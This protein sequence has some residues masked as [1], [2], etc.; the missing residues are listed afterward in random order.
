MAWLSLCDESAYLIT[1]PSV[2]PTEEIQR[3]CTAKDGARHNPNEQAILRSVSLNGEDSV[4]P[5][6]HGP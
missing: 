6:L 2:L 4:F 3:M 1:K 5:S